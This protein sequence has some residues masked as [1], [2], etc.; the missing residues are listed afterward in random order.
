[1]Y[2]IVWDIGNLPEEILQL[3]D[4][5]QNWILIE[6]KYAPRLKKYLNLLKGFSKDLVI[7]GGGTFLY[8][9]V[10]NQVK[11]LF[12]KY[13]LTSYSV[14]TGSKIIGLGVGCDELKSKFS[15]IS[16]KGILKNMDKIYF[17]EI[18]AH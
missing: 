14:L 2:T 16:V 13:I 4:K 9:D 12:V 8:D 18:K 3:F 5:H 15:K 10:K 6:Q 7:F 11:N 1:M 17:L